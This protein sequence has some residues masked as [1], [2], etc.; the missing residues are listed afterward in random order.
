MMDESGGFSLSVILSHSL[1]FYL[2]AMISN[3]NGMQSE[4]QIKFTHQQQQQQQK[5][6]QFLHISRTE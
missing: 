3:L 1:A 2:F 4:Q 5:M 6:V